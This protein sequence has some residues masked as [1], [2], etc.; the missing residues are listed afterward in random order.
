MTKP[1]REL[2]PH[3][4]EDWEQFSMME[5]IEMRTALVERMEK[6][7]SETDPEDLEKTEAVWMLR[8]AV[9]VVLEKI[10]KDIYE[11]EYLDEEDLKVYDP[12]Q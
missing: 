1:K 4:R 11:K 5:M 9:E 6:L 10:E 3:V 12:E 2:L 7:N 8:D